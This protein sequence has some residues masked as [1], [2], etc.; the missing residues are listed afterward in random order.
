VNWSDE[1][2]TVFCAALDAGF[3]GSFGER[4]RMAWRLFMD[5]LEPAAAMETLNTIIIGGAQVFRPSISEF[6]GAMRYD[7]ERPT[8][9][10]AYSRYFRGK[11]PIESSFLEL[12]GGWKRI[13]QLPL[14]DPEREP[15]ERHE[16]MA[17][18]DRHVEV[19]DQ[20]ET[21]TLA[22]EGG[23]RRFKPGEGLQLEE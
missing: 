15:R 13:G 2:W 3:P 11:H 10:E 1:Q 9:D 17:A 20:R 6:I 18:W 8:F 16:L 22:R 4:D 7:P 12:Q 21:V 14:C 5:D 23:L 19:A